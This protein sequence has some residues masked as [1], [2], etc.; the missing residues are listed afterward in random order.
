MPLQPERNLMETKQVRILA[1]LAM[2]CIAIG[3]AYLLSAGDVEGY[4]EV[5][6]KGWLI[7][8]L[9]VA[10][11]AVGT[12]VQYRAT[13]E[14]F[15]RPGRWFD[16]LSPLPLP[17]GDIVWIEVDQA[18]ARQ[19]RLFVWV[20]FLWPLAPLALW[21]YF[22]HQLRATAH[23]SSVLFSERLVDVMYGFVLVISVTLALFTRSRSRQLLR[24]RL[25]AEEAHLL[26]DPGN[27][28]IER[29]AWSTVLTDKSQLLV[30]RHLVGLGLHK[31]P[32]FPRDSL[33]GLVLARIPQTSYA[34]P[35][36]VLWAA[37]RRGNIAVI[38]GA[39]GF[40]VFVA[41][42]LLFELNPQW[43]AAFRTAVFAWVLRN[44]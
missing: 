34:Q 22:G 41:S 19:I 2:G 3:V 12:W 13:P 10:L 11:A 42:H 18:Y 14:M 40:A 16:G 32:R 38:V 30:G 39:V 8:L 36:Q 31:V 35:W 7:I 20:V 17:R 29:H 44:F 6:R 26:Y 1:V 23:G 33:R 43:R 21:I 4:R 9:G 28:E 24:T 27:G 5:Y 37:A 15:K 25:G